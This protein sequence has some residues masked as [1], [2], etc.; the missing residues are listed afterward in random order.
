VD[1]RLKLPAD[2]PLLSDGE[3]ESIIE[4]F[5]RAAFMAWQVG[6]DF[7]DIKQARLSGP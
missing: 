3:I 5:H 4:E 2:C 7:V 1:Q 6:F